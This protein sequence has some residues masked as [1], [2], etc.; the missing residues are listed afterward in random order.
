MP[1]H[2]PYTLLAGRAGA[3]LGPFSVTHAANQQSPALGP[4]RRPQAAGRGPGGRWAA[5]QRPP[6]AWTGSAHASDAG[7]LR[8]PRFRRWAPQAAAAPRRRGA[9]R[10]SAAFAAGGRC[11][12]VQGLGWGVGWGGVELGWVQGVIQWAVVSFSGLFVFLCGGASMPFRLV[13]CGLGA[14]WVAAGCVQRSDGSF[15][16]QWMHLRQLQGI[17]SNLRDGPIYLRPSM[18]C[19]QAAGGS[20]R[21]RRAPPGPAKQGAGRPRRIGAAKWMIGRQEKQS[22]QRGIEPRPPA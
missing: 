1:G 4:A 11:W 20:R 7:F 13:A 22:P 2:E 12:G 5:A 19:K 9:P 3:L 10:G 8:A 14:A 15:P 16:E 18:A 17:E 21:R 6:P